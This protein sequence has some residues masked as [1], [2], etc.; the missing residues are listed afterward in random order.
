MTV[1]EPSEMAFAVKSTCSLGARPAPKGP[2][3]GLGSPF[4]LRRF[5]A[6]NAAVPLEKDS[7][8]LG[9][10]RDWSANLKPEG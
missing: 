9:L 4:R 3:D 1:T 2:E 10:P 8:F 6:Q 5:M 7:L